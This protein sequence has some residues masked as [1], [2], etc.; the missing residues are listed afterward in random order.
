M[1]R[2]RGIGPPPAR[3]RPRPVERAAGFTL[4]ELL[5]ALAIFAL[6]SAF[7]FRGLNAMLES[8]ATL[9]RESRKWRDVTLF[10]GRLERDL[11]AVIPTRQAKGAS[12]TKLPAVSSAI[13]SAEARDGLSLTRSGAVLLENPLA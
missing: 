7:A 13:E 8:R 3:G 6:L 2:S 4:V 10:V 11:S 5:V 9:E 12:G 1:S